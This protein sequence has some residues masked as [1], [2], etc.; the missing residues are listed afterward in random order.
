MSIDFLAIGDIV[1]E[2]F[3]R[4]KDAS[5]HCTIDNE[6]CEICMRFGD[7]I[8]YEYAKLAVA[9]GN[10]SNAA[11]AASRLG[12]SSS[13]RAYVGEDRYGVEC[14]E[15]LKEEKVD[16][17]LMVT[18]P[19][20]NTNYHYVLWYGSE[21]TILVKHEEFSYSVPELSESP[22][23]VYLSSLAENSLPYHEAL[24]SFLDAHPETKLSFQ[25]GTFQMK[26]GKEALAPLYQRSDLFF[27]NKQE[28]ERILGLP[29]GTEEKVLLEALRALGPKIVVMT[30]GRDGAYAYDGTRFLFVPMYPD[31]REPF[32]RTGAGDAFASTVTSALALGKPLEEA[33]LWGPINSMAVVQ[34]VGA[35]DGLLTR[36]ALEAYL[37]KAPDTYAIQTL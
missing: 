18:E 29:G 27:C 30:D 11:I 37:G 5:V 15:K 32:E 23:W 13:L 22:K 24:V 4:L 33:L 6:R 28:A 34:Q 19:G 14:I 31:D 12:L 20:K 1:T 9:V 16:I 21:R 8:P 2:P 17:S 3:I 10:A 36:D 25:P 7:K 35:Q 26:L